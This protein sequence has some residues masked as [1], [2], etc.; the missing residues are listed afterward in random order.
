MFNISTIFLLISIAIWNVNAIRNRDC[1]PDDI[2]FANKVANSS[3]VVY[4]KP[5]AKTLYNDS[6]AMFYG[7]FR[8]DCILKGSPIDNVIQIMKAGRVDGKTY[9][10][11]LSVGRDYVIAFLKQDPLQKNNTN[12]FVPMDFADMPVEGNATSQLLADTCNLQQILPIRS[13]ALINDICPVVSTHTHCTPSTMKTNFDSATTG[14]GSI[15]VPG[16]YHNLTDGIRSKSGTALVDVDINK[17]SNMR[18]INIF[19][20]FMAIL[21]PLY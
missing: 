19:L 2:S 4:G 14:S 9:C 12:T 8:V 5:T 20:I 11:D 17:A 13:S 6:D 3:F 21:V 10:Q 7:T 16:Q 15:I 1:H 18:S